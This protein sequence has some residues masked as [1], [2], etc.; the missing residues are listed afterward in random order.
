MKENSQRRVHNPD[1]A[2]INSQKYRLSWEDRKQMRG[3]LGWGKEEGGNH[4]GG[5]PP[6]PSGM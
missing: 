1:P 4:K 2:Y 5:R 6:V 3:C